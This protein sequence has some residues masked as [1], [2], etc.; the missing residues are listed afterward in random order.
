MVT[1][2][3][4]KI[5]SQIFWKK[6]RVGIASGFRTIRFQSA[7]LSKIRNFVPLIIFNCE[8][9]FHVILVL[10]FYVCQKTVPAIYEQKRLSLSL[11]CLSKF[12][13]KVEIGSCCH[14]RAPPVLRRADAPGL[15]NLRN[16][17]N[18]RK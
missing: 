3:K 7:R 6:P 4:S 14:H 16:F 12:S 10:N 17:R 1:K 18:Q 9:I 11:L 15:A 5:V 13:L 8:P 2:I